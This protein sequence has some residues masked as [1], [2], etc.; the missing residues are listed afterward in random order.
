M[1]LKLL[2]VKDDHILCSIPLSPDDWIKNELDEEFDDFQKGLH[3][4]IRILAT[5]TN[6]NRV[7]MLRHLMK[8]E[9]L[10]SNFT[11]F[12]EDLKLN[13]KIIREHTLKLRDAGFLDSPKRGKYR[14][15]ECGEASFITMG[16]ALKRILRMIREEY[17]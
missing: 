8:H 14:L 12:R 4:H 1:G 13:P 9:D 3:S 10:T 2:L 16:L 11:D 17:E 5:M 6:E 15:S 7:Q